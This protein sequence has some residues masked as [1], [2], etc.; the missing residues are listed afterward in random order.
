M[1]RREV[2]RIVYPTKVSLR[3]RGGAGACGDAVAPVAASHAR[4]VHE[5][6]IMP[7]NYAEAIE[8]GN[9]GHRAADTDRAA[10]DHPYHG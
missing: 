2:R 10:A 6:C 7:E 8:I 5:G 1:Y 3:N 4:P 9:S